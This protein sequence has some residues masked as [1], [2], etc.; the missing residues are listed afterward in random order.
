VDQE[1]S[2]F[3]ETIG[4]KEP[5]PGDPA[6]AIYREVFR[7]SNYFILNGVFLIIKI[8]RSEKPFWGVGRKYIEL[9]T[10][11]DNYFLVLITQKKGGWFFSKRDV[12]S[13]IDRNVWKLRE[14]DDNYKINFPLPDNRSFRNPQDFQVK[15]GL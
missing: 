11:A 8:S 4:A 15:A 6:F 5:A 2:E 7:R 14:K 1:I 10:S 12:I 3:V 13:N 9:L